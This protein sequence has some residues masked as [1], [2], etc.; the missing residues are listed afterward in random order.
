MRI[1]IRVEHRAL[2][3]HHS[4]ALD[5]LYVLRVEK[6]EVG[7]EL[8][9]E[10]WKVGSIAHTRHI[11]ALVKQTTLVSLIRGKLFFEIGKDFKSSIK[12]KID[13]F[14]LRFSL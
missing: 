9:L 8:A 10:A 7:R 6:F 2:P 5:L 14:K 13:H 4:I 3:V 11:C 12:N 1:L